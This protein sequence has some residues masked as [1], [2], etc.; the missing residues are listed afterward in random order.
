MD[1]RPNFKKIEEKW[2]KLWNKDLQRLFKFDIN[3]KGNVYIIDSPPPFTSGDAHMGHALG[4]VWMDFIARFKRIEGYNVYLPQGWDCHGLPTELKVE[5]RLKIP[6]TDVER[7]LK[8]CREWTENSIESMKNTFKKLG[9]VPDWS[10]EYKTMDRKYKAFVQYTLI[11]MFEENLIYREEHPILWCPNCK[12]AISAEESGYIKRKDIFAYIKLPIK[13]ENKSILIA[14]TRPEMISACVVVLIGDGIY[15]ETKE[16]LIV[17]KVYAEKEGLEI[18]R[19]YDANELEEKIVE[20]PLI[21]RE[22]RIKRDPEVEY[23]FGTG[24]VWVCTYGDEMDIK[25]QKKYDLPVYQCIDTEGRII[26]SLKEINGLKVEDARKKIVEILKEKGYLYK[27]EEIEHNVLV[28]AERSECKHPIELIPKEQFFIRILDLKD[29]LLEIQK[30]IKFYPEWMRQ[31]LINWINSLSWDWVISRNRIW[32]LAFPFLKTKDSKIISVDL[33]DLPFDPRTDKEKLE[34]YKRIYGDIEPFS[35]VVDVW[36]ESSI[37]PL[38]IILYALIEEKDIDPKDLPRLFNKIKEYVPVDLRPQGYEIIRTWLFDT[39]VRV[40]LLT[41]KKPWKEVLIN[42]MVLA[43]DGR[44]MSK[45]LG[46]AVDPNDIIDKYSADALRYWALFSSH[47]DDYRFAW[48][49]IETGQAFLIKLWN[50]SRYIWMNCKNVDIKNKPGL[51][52]EDVEFLKRLE[53]LIAKS[54]S[55]VGEYKFQ[56]YIKLWRK[57]VWEEFANSYLEK[58]KMRVKQGDLAAKWTLLATLRIILAYLH[59]AFPFT[60]EEIYSIIFG[61]KENKKSIIETKFKELES[62]FPH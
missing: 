12:T 51:S 14:T 35:E 50:L 43:E 19:E 21:N 8:A 11:R 22:V 6:K 27:S 41:G 23:E 1:K 40:Y 47:G 55:L 62:L 61:K 9:F 53:K 30:D 31:R 24:I 18:I 5:N 57:F 26:N 29:K 42:G 49:D 2:T 59:P 58:N 54:H 37:T 20:I 44:K 15:V 39:L 16:G 45:S 13:E 7:F 32:G 34:K 33:E 36:V 25:W 38:A 3:K 46:N 10:K 48:K 52:K 56:E 17:S 28:H 60:T 4:W